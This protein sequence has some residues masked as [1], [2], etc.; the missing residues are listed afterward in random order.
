VRRLAGDVSAPQHDPAAGRL[1]YPGDEIDGS[2]L[3]GAV[4]ADEAEDFASF[5]IEAEIGDG[6]QA[7]EALAQMLD[8]E[9]AGHVWALV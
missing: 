8:E 1:D 3:A 5:Y 4:R 6:L 7:A 9:D 2:G